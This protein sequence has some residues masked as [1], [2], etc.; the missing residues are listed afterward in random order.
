M[1]SA[2]IIDA[3]IVVKL[4]VNEI[5]SDLALSLT[6]TWLRQGMRVFAP[7]L[8][9]VEVSHALFQKAK[10]G[11][12][13]IAETINLVENLVREDIVLLALPEVHS[14]ALE[15]ADS[16]RQRA[17]YDAHYLALAESLD[18]RIF[19]PP[20]NVSTERRSTN[21]QG[22]ILSERFNPRETR[23]EEN[24]RCS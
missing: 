21:S 9:L 24:S 5:H 4:L 18:W 6:H 14:R 22:S 12:L 20:T 8:M 3:S 2:V 19:G 10:Q 17:V 7:Y 11:Y 1:N 23:L 16:L 15:P 13:A